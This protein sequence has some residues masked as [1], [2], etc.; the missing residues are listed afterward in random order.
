M[1][2]IVTTARYRTVRIDDEAA[3]DVDLLE[4]AAVASRHLRVSRVCRAWL[5][6]LIFP[7]RRSYNRTRTEL[8]AAK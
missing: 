8:M 6:I 5:R 3:L 1:S 4:E 7:P 2:M